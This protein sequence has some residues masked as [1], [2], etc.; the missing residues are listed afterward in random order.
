MT[1]K[2]DYEKMVVF[3]EK[4]VVKFFGNAFLNDDNDGIFESEIKNKIKNYFV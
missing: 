2:Y 1:N 3:G 4:F